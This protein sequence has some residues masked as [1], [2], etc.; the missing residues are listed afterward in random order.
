MM[1]GN[2]SILC[3]SVALM[4][5]GM[6]TLAVADDQ[7]PAPATAPSTSSGATSPPAAP[8]AEQTPKPN[9]P[10]E[11]ICKREQMTGTRISRQKVCMTRREWDEEAAEGESRAH[12]EQQKQ[13]TDG[14]IKPIGP[15]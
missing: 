12:R 8:G 2:F 9:D 5:A 4:L 3:A 14:R 15:G 10:D 6:T 11:V 7:I 1:R 13:D